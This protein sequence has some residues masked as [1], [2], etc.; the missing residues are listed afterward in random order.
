MI[1]D[2]QKIRQVVENLLGNAIKFT[3]AG[4]VQLHVKLEGKDQVSFSITDTGVGLSPH[5][6]KDLFVPF[7]QS[8]TGRPPEPGTG[9]GLSISQHLIELMGGRIEIES[10]LGEGSRFYFSIML[11]GITSLSDDDVVDL[12][13]ITGYEGPLRRI[14][15]VDDVLVN[16]TLIQEILSSSGFEVEEREDIESALTYLSDNSSKLPHALIVD[17]RMPGID[18]LAFSR[19]VRKRYGDR[20]KIILMSAS[21]LAFDPQIAFDAGCDD[22]LLK[23]FR[24]QDLLDRLAR[25]LKLV[26]IRERPP[27]PSNPSEKLKHLDLESFDRVKIELLESARRGDVRAIRKQVESWSMEYAELASLA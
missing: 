13:N 15:V 22:F 10:N 21:V 23:P 3:A 2:A 12:P 4:Q 9:L 18:G 20:P 14:L 27:P 8:V 26:W 1:G 16:R 19:R 24:E 5:D 25:A 6:Q 7:R 11:P 17:L